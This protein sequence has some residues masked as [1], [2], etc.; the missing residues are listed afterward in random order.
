MTPGSLV[1]KIGRIFDWPEPAEHETPFRCPLQVSP[2]ADPDEFMFSANLFEVAERG[3]GGY[4]RGSGLPLKFAEVFNKDIDDYPHYAYR[5]RRM[6]CVKHAELPL[7]ALLAYAIGL[8]KI[9]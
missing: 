8:V 5:T 1:P 3:G 2:D 4:E 6:W 7:G 9:T